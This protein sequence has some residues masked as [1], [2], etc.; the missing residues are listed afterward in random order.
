VA[1]S[2]AHTLGA[3]AASRAAWLAGAD[4]WQPKLLQPFLA[5]VRTRLKVAA[6]PD[7]ALARYMSRILAARVAF[8]RWPPDGGESLF[9]ESDPDITAA[10]SYFPRLSALLSGS[11]AVPGAATGG[12]K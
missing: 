7:E 11:S 5:R 2:V 6:Q 10:I 3:D 1:D 8:V 9:L 4:Q 12:G